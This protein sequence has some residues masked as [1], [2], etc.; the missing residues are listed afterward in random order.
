MATLGNP[1]KVCNCNRTMT[2]DGA[3]LGR[4]LG[5]EAIP[6]FT[7]LC[8]KEVDGFTSALGDASC[9]VACTQEAPLFTELAAGAGASTELK[10]V[11]IREAAGWSAE[12]AAATAKIAALLALA[13]LPDPQPVAVSSY[14]SKGEVLVIGPAEAAIAWAEQLADSLGVSVLITTARGA[15]LPAT[16]R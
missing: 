10:F 12:G 16:R 8:R 5:R 3:A 7:E 6:I 13:D 2:L 4:A 9:T 15:E 1:L 14:A 11:N